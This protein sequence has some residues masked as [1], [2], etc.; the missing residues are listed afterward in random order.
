MCERDDNQPE[1]D[2]ALF[3]HT[4]GRELDE[5]PVIRAR[6]VGDVIRASVVVP[7]VVTADATTDYA[8]ACVEDAIPF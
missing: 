1:D 4:F 5:R 6:R 8:V 2:Y 7:V 3:L